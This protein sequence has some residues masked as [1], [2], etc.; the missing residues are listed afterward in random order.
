MRTLTIG[1]SKRVRGGEK[2]AASS[3]TVEALAYQ[4]RGGVCALRDSSAQRRL[5][6]LDELQ[7]REI[8]NRL[9]KPRWGKSVAGEPSSNMPPWSS[10]EI[11]TILETWRALHVGK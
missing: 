5:S 9:I 11:E 1:K 10:V 3:S 8:A 2:F 4:L 6:E 7:M